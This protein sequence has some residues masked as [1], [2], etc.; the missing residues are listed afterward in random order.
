[1]IGIIMLM[2]LVTKNGILLVD[3]ANQQREA[4]HDRREAPADRGPH[5]PAPDHHDHGWP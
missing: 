3:F 4:G 1:M 2:G 5:P